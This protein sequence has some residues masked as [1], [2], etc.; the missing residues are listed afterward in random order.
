MFSFRVDQDHSLADA[1]RTSS[2]LNEQRHFVLQSREEARF[3]KTLAS[4]LRSHPPAH[5]KAHPTPSG[6]LRIVHILT[7]PDTETDC[8]SYHCGVTAVIKIQYL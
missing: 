8:H 5:Q 4:F 3:E 6:R 1:C 7:S 2:R